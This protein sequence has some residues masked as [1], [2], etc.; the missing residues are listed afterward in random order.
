M[1]AGARIVPEPASRVA[2]EGEVGAK[3]WAGTPDGVVAPDCGVRAAD[4]VGDAASDGK[5]WPGVI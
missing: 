4:G 5:I 1:A 3:G 2:N